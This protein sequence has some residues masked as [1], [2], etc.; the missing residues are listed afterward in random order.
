[1]IVD[2]DLT[3][4]GISIASL[5]SAGFG[6]YFG[7][8]LKKKGENLATHEDFQQVL[9]ELKETTHTTK[10]IEN[11]ISDV[12]WDRQKRWEL[13]R[14]TLI[15][16]A[17]KV[18]AAKDTLVQLHTIH[19][20][21]TVTD[22]QESPTRTA[23]RIEISAAWFAAT[24]ELARILVVASM[25]CGAEM[26]TALADFT[27]F[28]NDLAVEIID[29]HPEVLM[30]RK[31]DLAIRYNAVTNA[32]RKEIGNDAEPMFLSNVS[33]GAQVPGSPIPE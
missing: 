8:Y 23:K 2:G 27:M 12:F 21:L 3:Y 4:A 9:T 18:A 24:N 20:P 33:L 6:A 26:R 16:A 1:M 11:K 5:I 17:N 30:T 25:A 28:A 13:K 32:M 15:E 7:A 14:D 29:G 19:L 31:G 10:E 22:T